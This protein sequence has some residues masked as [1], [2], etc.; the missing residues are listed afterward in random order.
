MTRHDWEAVALDLWKLLDDIDTL[1]D[2]AKVDDRLFRDA[3][4]NVQRKRFEVLDGS[5]WEARWMQRNPQD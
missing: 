4:R 1:D 3:V 5:E 2:A